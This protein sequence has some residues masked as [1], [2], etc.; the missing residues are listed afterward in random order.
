MLESARRR[1]PALGFAVILGLG[2]SEAHASPEDVLGFG[3]RSSAMGGTG[4]AVGEGYEAVPGNPALLSLARRRELTLG[5]TGATFD[6]RARERISYG[7]L[8]GS[9]I[10]ATLPVPFGGLLKDEPIDPRGAIGAVWGANG[11]LGGRLL[12][13]AGEPDLWSTALEV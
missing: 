12:C 6:L 8:H 4:A 11:S 2:A 7:R 5:F 3:P 9:I 13:R 10:G 1:V